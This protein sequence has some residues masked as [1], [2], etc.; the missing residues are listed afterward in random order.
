MFEFDC[1][2]DG[3]GDIDYVQLK[4]TWNGSTLTLYPEYP[5]HIRKIDVEAEEGMFDTDPSN[6]AFQLVWSKEKIAVLVAKHGDGMG[7]TVHFELPSP[8]PEMLQSLR[9]ALR[10]WKTTFQQN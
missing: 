6:G 8:P 5:E 4:L 2:D 3:F 1:T 10:K 7:G 9:D